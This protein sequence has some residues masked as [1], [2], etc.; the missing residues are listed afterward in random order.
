MPNMDRFQRTFEKIRK[1]KRIA[2]MPFL[3]GGDPNPEKGLEI[4]KEVA[5]YSDGLE[6]GL[7][8]SDPVADGPTVQAADTR[9]LKAGVTP[10]KVFE[11][12]KQLRKE[13]DIPIT[14]LVYAN[15][16]YQRGIEKFYKDAKIAGVD[17]VLVPDVPLEESGQFVQAAKHA[18]I[19]PIFL[20]TPATNKERRKK[21][22]RE[23]E[24]FIYIVSVL[25]VTGARAEVEPRTIQL[26]KNLKQ[27]TDLPLVVGFGI[28]TPEHVKTLRMAGADGAIVGSALIKY[29]E[30]Y[31]KTPKELQ[32]KLKAY[33]GAF[34]KASL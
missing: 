23:A 18:D 27:E 6:L 7:P 13:T 21:I 32:K 28:S 5:K 33:L 29:M 24:G 2:F 4:L 11:I 9:A 19:R 25:G 26:V 31:Y 1:E 3:V 30:P 20:I 12:V 34:Q 16:V 10:D 22:L 17:G 8:F 14:F 15:L